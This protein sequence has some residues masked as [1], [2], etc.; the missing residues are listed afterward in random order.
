MKKFTEN[1]ETLHASDIH[2]AKLTSEAAN[3]LMPIVGELPEVEKFLKENTAV[4][5]YKKSS[6][7]YFFVSETKKVLELTF[8]AI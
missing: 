8:T 4:A 6:N 7:K 5:V 3:A 1:I 2:G